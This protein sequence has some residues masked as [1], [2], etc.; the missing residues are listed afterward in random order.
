MTKYTVF[1]DDHF[2][3]QDESERYQLGNFETYETAVAA[4]QKIIDEFLQ[5]HYTVGISSAEL[6]KLYLVFGE[7]PFIIPAELTPP[8][9][10]AEYAQQRCSEICD[11][12]SQGFE[13]A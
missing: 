13:K 5:A 9:S 8:F 4:C 3:Y 6:Y 11:P 1:V 2:H 10:S 12:P 7:D